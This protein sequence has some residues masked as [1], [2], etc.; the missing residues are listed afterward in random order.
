MLVCL[1]HFC[2]FLFDVSAYALF[3]FYKKMLRGIFSQLFFIS[4][5][6]LVNEPTVNLHSWLTFFFNHFN[7]GKRN[8][9]LSQPNQL[10]KLFR[11]TV[12][13]IFINLTNTSNHSKTQ[14]CYTYRIEP[15]Y[16]PVIVSITQ[17]LVHKMSVIEDVIGN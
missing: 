1:L 14:G 7:A 6:C 10:L 8:T 16:C 17:F 5:N 12:Q 13:Q 15:L 2:Y 11:D 9:A 4:S 3:D